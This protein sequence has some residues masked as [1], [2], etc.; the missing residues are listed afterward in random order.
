METPIGEMREFRIAFGFTRD[1]RRLPVPAL[2]YHGLMK[3][4]PQVIGVY[5]TGDRLA[6]L[7]TIARAMGRERYPGGEI[8]AP[9]PADVAPDTEGTPEHLIDPKRTTLLHDE[10]RRLIILQ[11]HGTTHF[12]I[13]PRGD[14]RTPVDEVERDFIDALE[15][16]TRSKA[17]SVV[18]GRDIFSAWPIILA[19]AASVIVFLVVLL[20]FLCR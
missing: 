16:T 6:L 4:M 5:R 3:I 15:R 8:A 7:L 14:R 13:A 10:R 1:A 11:V 12:V 9:R 19:V 20:Q 2:Q 17:Q 18:C